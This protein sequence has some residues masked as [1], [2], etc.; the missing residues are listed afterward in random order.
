MAS[1]QALESLRQKIEHELFQPA[2]TE[3]VHK[4]LSQPE[5]MAKLLQAIIEGI[6]KE[7]IDSDLTA[8]VGKS[9]S[10]KEVNQLLLKKIAERLKEKGVV[11]GDFKGGIKV[12][13]HKDKITIDLSEEALKDLMTSF[14]RKEFREMFFTKGI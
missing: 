14:V 8:F 11:I 7:G 4:S 9:V 3:S 12:V 5:V 6:E 13:L 10:S 2:L 1:K